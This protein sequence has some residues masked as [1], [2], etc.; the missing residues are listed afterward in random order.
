MIQ[1]MRTFHI[2]I[3]LD[4]A[5]AKAT[6]NNSYQTMHQTLA[7]WSKKSCDYNMTSKQ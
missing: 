1:M 3:N 5:L 2:L 7:D 6:N 4:E